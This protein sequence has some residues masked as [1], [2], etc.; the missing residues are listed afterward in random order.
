[1][2]VD[3]IMNSSKPEGK[4]GIRWTARNQPEHLDSLDDLAF[5]SHAHEQMQMK[6]ASE[7]Q[8][9]QRKRTLSNTNG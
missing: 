5:L 6:T 7:L 3:W 8:H 4:R 2:V 9:T 1:M